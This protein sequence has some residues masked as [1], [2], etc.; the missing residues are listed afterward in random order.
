ME[1]QT[2]WIEEPCRNC[3]DPG[4][5]RF[6][7]NCGQRKGEVRVSM[8]RLLADVLE[9]QLSLNAALPRTLS[10]L[11]LHPGRLTTEYVRGR[12]ASY[13]APFR[14]YLVASLIFF[15]SLSF[16][17]RLSGFENVNVRTDQVAAA[18]SIG[19]LEF[20]T[21]IEPLDSLLADRVRS[22]QEMGT[23]EALS[24]VFSSLLQR[25]P[26]AMFVLLPLFAFLLKLLYAGSGRY[27]VEHFVFALHYHAFAFLLFTAMLP[28][29]GTFVGAVLFLW[30]TIYLP[31]ALKRVYSQGVGVTMVKWF[32]LGTAYMLLLLAVLVGTLI[33]AV[34]ML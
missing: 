23:S 12:I 6:C 27:Y 16:M 20:E 29:D 34:V 13:I 1:S 3:S 10:A 2:D 4:P 30:L 21:G 7:R 9:D 19:T 22:F 11:F 33:V 25:A 18:D 8:R 28:L 17:S 14:L 31:I 26:T 32:V 15:L 5:G 24:A